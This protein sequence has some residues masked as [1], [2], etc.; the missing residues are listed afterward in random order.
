MVRRLRSCL[1]MCFYSGDLAPIRSAAVTARAAA[2]F[3]IV[4]GRAC[5]PRSNRTIV[6][7]VTP[8]L[9]ASS[10]CDSRAAWREARRPGIGYCP[11]GRGDS[12]IAVLYH[13]LLDQRDAES[14][15]LLGRE[16]SSRSGG[17]P[18]ADLEPAGPLSRCCYGDGRGRTYPLQG[19]AERG[20]PHLSQPVARTG[21]GPLA[22]HRRA[23]V[24]WMAPAWPP[25]AHR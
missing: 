3:R 7:W 15:M 11:D 2:I 8:A 12:I 13:I 1:T 10:R 17:R 24:M 6:C 23:S 18:H 9:A 4:D 22:R 5:S 19:R 14:P 16:H 21:A 20:G 25:L